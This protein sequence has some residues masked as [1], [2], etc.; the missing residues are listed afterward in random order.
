[1]KKCLSLII[2]LSLIICNFV[3]AS[4][5]D[6][7][8]GGAFITKAEFEEL[9]NEFN[10]QVNRYD[11]SISAKVDGKIALYVKALLKGEQEIDSVLNKFSEDRRTF[12][13]AIANPTTC[14]QDDLYIATSGYWVASYPV[15]SAGKWTGY[16]LCGLNNLEGGHYKTLRE[17]NNGKTSKYIFLDTAK[18]GEEETE[19]LYLNDN[20]RKYLQY[21]IY[22]SGA[23]TGDNTSWDTVQS[24]G[25]PAS[26]EFTN[27]YNWSGEDRLKVSGEG[28][29]VNC[30]EVVMLQIYNDDFDT[31]K[32]GVQEMYWSTGMSGSTIYT[33]QA[34]CLEKKNRLNWNERKTNF[35]LGFRS[36]QQAMTHEWDPNTGDAVAG[37]SNSYNHWNDT[38]KTAPFIPLSFNVPKITMLE[39][40]KIAVKDVSDMIGKPAYYYSGLPLC[41]LPTEVRNVKIRVIPKI[42]KKSASDTTGMTLA[43]KKSQFKNGLISAEPNDDIYYRKDWAVGSIP[44]EI[45]IELDED[46]VVDSRGDY[47]WIKANATNTNCTVTLETK[48]ITVY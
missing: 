27:T 7:S 17:K 24:W 10:E 47:L 22:I 3:Y 4:V 23:A 12:V 38:I 41:S 11:S 32:T 21:Y 5:V 42:N 6:A 46:D 40:N 9:K 18:I 45:T 26:I 48:L 14:A 2:I 33:T 8:D 39:G 1:M 37:E 30:T 16:A 15:G 36:G 43:I 34:G 29:T 28:Q 31:S 44:D 20:Y 25:G 13:Q 19:V 35:N